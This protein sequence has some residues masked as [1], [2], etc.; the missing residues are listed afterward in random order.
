MAVSASGRRALRLLRVCLSTFMAG[1]T[2]SDTRICNPCLVDGQLN[3]DG[4]QPVPMADGTC[5]NPVCKPGM[6]GMSTWL[7]GVSPVVLKCYY[8]AY[9]APNK[10]PQQ[11]ALLK[12]FAKAVSCPGDQLSDVTYYLCQLGN[13]VVL[14]KYW[15]SVADPELNNNWPKVSGG[16]LFGDD[17]FIKTKVSSCVPLKLRKD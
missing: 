7:L 6:G 16:E 14:K 2:D 12:Q 10:S 3:P 9:M 8:D 4:S 17:P 13:G 15:K 5:S 1:E 11:E